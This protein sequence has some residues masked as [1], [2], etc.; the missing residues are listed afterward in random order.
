MTFHSG[1]LLDFS[2]GQYDNY[3]PIQVS[4][5]INTIANNGT[6]MTPYLYKGLYGDTSSYDQNKKELNKVKTEQK[7][8]DRVHEGFRAVMTYGL[9]NGYI[10][11]TYKPAGKTGT[12]QSFVDTDDDKKVDTETITTTLKNTLKFIHNL[13]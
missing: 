5:Y 2:I 6:R 4:Q 13:I 3:T 7:Y 9:G 12:S 11:E 8:M 10:N 1:L